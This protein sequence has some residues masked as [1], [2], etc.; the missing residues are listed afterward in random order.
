MTSKANALAH[1]NPNW[2]DAFNERERAVLAY[3]YDIW[4]RPEQRVPRTAIESFGILA[5][6]GW[7]KAL[8]LDTL[9]P[10]PEGWTLL[11]NIQVG[12]QVFDE[13]G[14]ICRVTNVFDSRPAKCYRLTFSD[15]I[16]IDACANHQWVTFTHYERKWFNRRGAALP[17][18]WA[19]KT[20][21]T[22]Q[23]V[24]DTIS[25]GARRDA[26]HCIPLCESL[27]LPNVGLP[28]DPYL[29]GIWLGD[30][31]SANEYVTTAD[32]EIAEA[33]AAAGYSPVAHCT[34]SGCIELAIGHPLDASIPRKRN[35]CTTHW[36][37]QLS[38]L[39]VLGRKHVP[40][41]YLRASRTQRLALLQ[42]LLDSDGCAEKSKA[43]FCNTNEALSNAVTEL[44]R[45]LGAKPTQSEGR[46]KLYGK[47]C[48]PKWRVTWRPAPE[49]FRLARKRNQ[50]ASPGKQAA[51][52]NHRMIV[53]AELI[54][55]Q[56]MR[57]LT[58]DSPNHMYLAGIGMIPTHNS[59]AI[60]AEVNRR[61]Q[62]GECRSPALIAPNEKRV[63][64]VQ[65]AFLIALS[66]PWFK[67]E[68]HGDGVRW[69]NGVT[70]ETFTPLAPGRSRSG[71]FDACWA[72]EIVD[73]QETS[74]WD[75]FQNILTATRIGQGLLLWD[76][77]S[78]GRNPIIQYLL[79]CNDQN[80][81]ANVI[82]RGCMF[83]NP[84]LSDSYF[85]REALLYTKGSRRYREEVMGEVFTESAGALWQQAWIDDHRISITPTNMDVV[86]VA[87]DPSLSDGPDADEAG[88]CVA[89][90][91]GDGHIAVLRD[92]SGRQAPEKW[93]K[94]A[95][96]RC[97]HDASGIVY[98]RNHAGDTP[99]DLI[100][101]HAE[102][103]GLRVEVLTND[104][105]PFPRRTPG[106]IYVRSVTSRESKENRAEAPAA[107]SS[108]GRIHHVGVLDGL[109][110]ELL[111]WEPGSKS[112]NRLDA[113]VWA[114]SELAGLRLNARHTDPAADVAGAGDMQKQLQDALRGR[115]RI[116]L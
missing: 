111:S 46:A 110:T 113:Y 23:A 3:D 101:V 43:E 116:G 66:P 47:D 63:Q 104:Q 36:R 100:K 14:R 76:T 84:L 58:V 41:Q 37:R 50:I 18:Y 87:I 106:V 39:G 83:D 16:H 80:P 29:L 65:S 88:V 102:H 68:P 93:A 103:V 44:L 107:L 17:E 109:E 114:V 49:H 67:G 10:T 72:T 77:T 75:A 34:H 51:R 99:R 85:R 12:D 52:N 86:I 26:N 13:R 105:Q 22:T 45:S 89:G 20:P 42:G 27:S 25:Y 40:P 98:E 108:H 112:P 38:D 78:K 97:R 56:P 5:G 91:F 30:G 28:I 92:L 57:C 31:S 73:W 71:N 94:A 61:V 33:F 2:L 35:T 90:R 74:R 7:G 59:F 21:L 95:V 62:A 24:V 32:V 1:V 19:A 55:A 115:G 64:E 6:R 9:I 4:L 48:G 96:D 15:G 70:T 81:A 8:A 53:R 79:A 11:C 82:R 54:A 69:P 60:A